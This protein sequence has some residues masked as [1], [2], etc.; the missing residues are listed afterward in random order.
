MKSVRRP[1]V[2]ALAG[3]VV[4]LGAVLAGC[5]A[6]A[7]TYVANTKQQTYFKVPHGWTSIKS[8]ALI[9]A[10]TG[11]TNAGDMWTV[12]F[13]ASG[14]P[15]ADH[16]LPTVPTQPFVYATAAKVPSA[17]SNAL[18]YN[19][20]KDMFLPVTSDDRTNATQ[21]GF[22]LT[23]FQLLKSTTIAA[24]QGIHGIREIFDYTYPGG[25]VVTFDQESLT[26]ADATSA[27][28]LL[29]HC[30]QTCYQQNQAAINTVM[31]SFTVRSP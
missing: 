25:Q 17:T 13:D 12:G 31:E 7:Y 2:S 16:V 11:G 26:D 6:P 15:S 27:F 29:I 19:L 18:S 1:G 28:M 3:L 14:R 4:A 30:T 9:K 24:G 23:G 20:L 10:L 5:S 22:P 8:T 21:E